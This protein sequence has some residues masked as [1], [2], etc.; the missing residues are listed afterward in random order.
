MLF[1]CEQRM[2]TESDNPFR[3]LPA[4]NE[5]LHLPRVAALEERHAHD[6]IVEAIRAELTL[7]RTQVGKGQTLN[8]ACTP[9]TIAAAIEQRLSRDSQPRLRSVINATGI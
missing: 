1:E 7:I 5:I 4:V 9:E 6:A 3:S 2:P 8:G